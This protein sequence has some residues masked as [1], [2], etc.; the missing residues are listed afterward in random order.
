MRINLLKSLAFAFCLFASLNVSAAL[1]GAYT[2]GAGAAS[3]TNYVTFSSAV[4]DMAFGT[5]ADGGPINGAGVSGPVTFTVAAGTYTEQVLI[6]AITG[7]SA[8]NTITFNGVDPLTRIV[9]RNS[10]TSGDYTIRLNGADYIR[11]DNLGIENTGPTYGFGIQLINLAEHNQITNCRVLLPTTTTGSTKIGIMAGTGYS[12]Y[13][14]NVSDLLISDNEVIGGYVGIAANG[15]SGFYAQGISVL[16]NTVTDA[17]FSGLYFN[18]TEGAIVRENNVEMRLGYASGYG[19]NMRYGNGFSIDRNRFYRQGA[20]GIYILSANA[21]VTTPSQISNNMV[22][23]GYQTT[24]TAYG[25]YMSTARYLNIYHNSVLLD[26]SGT[27]GY[28]LYLTGS[29]SVNNDIRNNSF[30]INANGTSAYAM[31]IVSPSYLTWCDYNNYYT[32]GPNIVYFAGAFP[33]LAALQSAY[34]AYNQNCQVQWPNYISSSDLHTFGPP[35]NNW[36]FNL[37]SMT[38]DFDNDPRPSPPDLVKDVGADDHVVAPFDADIVA[39][40]NPTVVALGPNTVTIT[41]QNNGTNSLNGTNLSL[42]YSTDGGTTWPVTESFTPT[43]LAASGSQQNFSFASQ[44]N[45][46]V[47]GNYNLCVRMN[48]QVVGDPDASDQLCITACTGMAGVYTVNSLLPTSGNNYNSFADLATALSGC[49]VGGPVTVNVAPGVYNETFTI[50]SILGVSATNTVTIN[51]A[52][53]SLVRIEFNLTTANASVITLDDA[54]YVTFKN[55]KVKSLNGSYGSCFKLTNTAD[56]NTID[57]CVM[58]LPVATSAYHIGVLASGS[59][60][61]TTGNNANYLTVSNSFIRNGYYG[62]RLNGVNTTNGLV[63]NRVLNTQITDYY[64]Y[65]LYS[66][67]ADS[68]EYIGNT[69]YA[70]SSGTFSNFSYGLYAYYNQGNLRFENN[71][72][73]TVGNY[74]MYVYGGNYNNTGRGSILNNMIGANWLSTGTPYGLYLYNCRDIDI[75]HN[76]VD[77]GGFNGRTVY[78]AGTVSDSLRFVNNIFSAGGSFPGQGGQAFYTAYP[79]GIQTMDYNMYFSN[80][81]Q[82]VYWN[83]PSYTDLAS[84]QTAVP[85]FNVNSVEDEPGFIGPTNLHVVCSPADNLGTPT[86]VGFDIDDQARSATTPDIGADEFTGISVSTSL[87]PDVSSCDLYQLYGD[88]LNF[89]TFLWNGSSTGDF[90]NIALTDTVTVMATDANN[91]RAFDTIIV[92]IDSLPN[93]PFNNGTVSQCQL[94]ILDAQ[95]AGSTFLWSTGATTQTIAPTAS[96]DY[97]VNI[98]TPAGCSLEDTV[99]VNLFA[100]AVAQLGNDTT[101]CLGIGHMLNGGSGPN[102]TT[103]QWST[104]A[105]SQIVI[106]TSPGA[107][108]VTVTSPQGCPAEDTINLFI[109]PAPVVNLGPDRTEC[110]PIVLDAANPGNTVSWSTGSTS[111]TIPVTTSGSYSVTVTNT[112]G[113][114]STDVVNIVMAVPPTVA[115]GPNQTLCAGQSLTLD[116]GNVGSTYLWSNGSTSQTITTSNPGTFIVNVT[117]P[118]TGCTGADTIE[119]NAS[120]LTVNL[121][122]DRIICPGEVVTLDAGAIPTNYL[123]S[124]G[125]TT[126]TIQVSTAGTYSVQVSDNLGCVLNDDIT[127][128]TG[129]APNAVFTASGTSVPLFAPIQFTDASTNGATS[130]FWDFGD[131]STSTLQNPSHSYVAMGSFNVCLTVSNGTCTNTFCDE[132]IINAPVEI[133]DPLFEGAVQVYPNPN[134]GAFSIDFD[135]SKAVDMN[136][137]VMSLTGQTVFNRDLRG[138]RVHHEAIDLRNVASGMYFVRIVS[139]KGDE[140]IKKVIK[141]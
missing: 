5:R 2:I 34:I 18:Y 95:N 80:G 3:A 22:G 100:N 75:I 48:P 131:G 124:N 85:A 65:G 112:V 132:V 83:G 57:S 138:V 127:L 8:T 63:G 17:Y 55:I 118:S 32:Q 38:V 12:A 102:G 139:S 61:S 93:L 88:T 67:Y 43:A 53:T 13:A 99:T 19:M 108:S 28:A 103:Y 64:Y 60:Y 91:C 54:D 14:N 6:P 97:Y 16:N 58:E 35:L 90:I 105:T 29:S 42:Q 47:S 74:G 78:V 71:V 89:E 136:I 4:S 69:I 86:V 68:P 44:W 26:H 81:T 104:G 101:F 11:F 50:N 125:S 134:N 70:R 24:G 1:S 122:P 15:M 126:Q 109:L 41:I 117:N 106:V 140:L 129:T 120:P 46:S 130:W 21:S 128:T 39:I 7:A 52:D 111:Q 110:G 73:H 36:A 27:N 87:G 92:T 72:I 40:V 59:S 84:W 137:T 133:I 113:C 23:G 31:Y 37:P 51:G 20:Y 121:G 10:T 45:V 141:E 82:L 76:S 66:Y 94:G 114:P 25:I 115:L 30:A 107:Y 98:T 49:G 33:T 119:V 116:A 77:M 9:T 56:H 62:I 123:W 135:L 96:G 79:N